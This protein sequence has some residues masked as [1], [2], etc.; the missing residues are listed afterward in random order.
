MENDPA[1]ERHQGGSFIHL[2]EHFIEAIQLEVLAQEGMGQPDVVQLCLQ[3]DD[4]GDIGSLKA[5]DSKID[6]LSQFGIHPLCYQQ[7]E[8]DRTSQQLVGS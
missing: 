7:I 3:L 4:R 8:I 5:A 6:I 2:V 1:M